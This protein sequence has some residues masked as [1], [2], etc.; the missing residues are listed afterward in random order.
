MI[1]RVI[2]FIVCRVLA[3]L[4]PSRFRLIPRVPDMTPLLRQFRICSFG[5]EQPRGV[6]PKWHFSIFLQSFCHAEVRELYHVHRWRYMLS[7]VLSGI[8]VEERPGRQ[9]IVHKA[10]DIYSMNDTVIHRLDYAAPRTW[11]LFIMF[12]RNRKRLPGGWG[13]YDRDTSNYT[14]WNSAIPEAKRVKA[15]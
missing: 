10:G 4:F 12:G 3:R 9:F 13:Y 1:G 15:L 14:P 7:F 5:K 8:F 6:P 11:T 2:E